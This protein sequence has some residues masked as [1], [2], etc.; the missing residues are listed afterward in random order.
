M[1]AFFFFFFFTLVTGPRRSLSRKLSDAR[2]YEPQIHDGLARHRFRSLDK[3]VRGGLVFK[4]HRLVYHS[5]LG[6]TVIKKKKK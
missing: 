1:T 4:V 6:L 5:T 2:V 3:K